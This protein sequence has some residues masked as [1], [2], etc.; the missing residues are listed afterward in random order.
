LYFPFHLLLATC[1]FLFIQQQFA[2][3]RTLSDLRKAGGGWPDLVMKNMKKYEKEMS[4]NTNIWAKG[5]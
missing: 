1:N 2:D 5:A 3:G 4:F